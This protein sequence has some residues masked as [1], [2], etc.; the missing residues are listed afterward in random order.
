M[1]RKNILSGLL[2]DD[3]PVPAAEQGVAP[4]IKSAGGTRGLGALGAVT[5]S[6]D[7]LAARAEAASKLEAQLAEGSVIV[8]ID[9]HLIER[10]FIADRISEDEEMFRELVAAIRERGQDSPV[11]LRPHPDRPGHYQ[12]AFGHRRI[13][14]ALELGI[15][16][17]AVV[18]PLSDTDH[19]IAQ[20]QENSARADLSFIERAQFVGRLE[21]MGF[22][23]EVMMASLGI[24]KTTLSKMLS[25]CHRIP[26]DILSMILDAKG[27]GRDRWHELSTLF[28]G[29]ETADRA[30]HFTHQRA[31]QKAGGVEER[32]QALLRF[33]KGK[34]SALAASPALRKSWARPDGA[35]KAKISDDGKTFTIALKAARA[36]DFGAYLASRLDGL[37]E[38]FEEDQRNNGD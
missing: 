36:A 20:G 37:Y 10:S 1:A 24:D 25:V 6:I 30:R 3:K 27:I 21:E 8:E 9:P 12:T 15:P 31:F 22:S 32:F 23:R 5:R 11:L 34:P 17:R 16:V 28:D 26:Q 33:L 14:A 2:N 13:R 7:A 4:E 38:A 18:K 19:V 35:V 29:P